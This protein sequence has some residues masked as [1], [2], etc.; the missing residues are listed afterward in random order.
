MLA[1]HRKV[2][3]VGAKALGAKRIA[4][5]NAPRPDGTA[6]SLRW[7]GSWLWLEMPPPPALVSMY[8]VPGP[9]AQALH[10]WP[11]DC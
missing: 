3:K 8:Y 6:R 7:Q 11:L 9:G 10:R 2:E 4:R 5:A 1:E